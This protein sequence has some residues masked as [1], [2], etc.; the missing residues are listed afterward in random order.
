MLS[1]VVAIPCDGTSAILPLQDP[2]LI[3]ALLMMIIWVVPILAKL[4]RL[5]GLVLLIL[6]GMIVGT[7]VLGVLQRDSQL[8]LLEK[9]GLLYIMLLAGIQ[10]D[11]SNF[12]RLGRR[13]LLF[14]LLTFS[15]PFGLGLLTGKIL[16]LPFL[17]TCIIG[18]IFSPHVLIAYPTIIRLGLAQT[19]SVGVTVGATA[20]TSFLTLAAFS[21]IQG[22]A[23]GTLGLIFWIK[24]LLG[25]PI[26][27]A[28]S[29][30]G[31]PKIGRLFINETAAITSQY[32]FV[33]ATLFFIAGITSLLGIDAIIGAFLA[34][35]A[36]NPLVLM[37][38]K[39]MENVV[40]VGNSLFIP[41]FL[42]SVG[43]LCNPTVFTNNPAIL[44][45]TILVFVMSLIGK[46]IPA[47]LVS[48][49]F[50]YSTLEGVTAFSLTIA[51][52]ALVV[53]IVLFAQKFELISEELFNVSIAYI[54]LTCLMGTNLTEWAAPRLLT[55]MKTRDLA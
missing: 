53:V 43:V 10:M 2:I 47:A 50:N 24:L 46:A 25:L 30:W 28:M 26:L 34:G 49:L 15:I 31:V 19:E 7:H 23:L 37:K 8:I 29:F 55:A 54:L 41:I 18:L 48:K 27:M 5:P 13:S 14:G 45:T 11:L 22:S 3:F 20:I 6:T 36:L 38:S 1:K 52:A 33:L 16:D 35:L 51:R 32:A 39:L 17:E 4:S 12:Q 9:I 40:F 21:I 42:I 44:S